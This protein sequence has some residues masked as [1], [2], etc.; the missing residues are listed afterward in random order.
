MYRRR[1]RDGA[2][3]RPGADQPRAVRRRRPVLHRDRDGQQPRAARDRPRTAAPASDGDGARAARDGARPAGTNDG[4]GAGPAGAGAG[5]KRAGTVAF[6]DGHG[7]ECAWAVGDDACV[8]GGVL[9]GVW[10]GDDKGDD[11]GD[12]GQCQCY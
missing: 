11:H 6:D 7:V 3:P 4:H 2:L 8:V 1:D 10:L 9:G 5:A 12:G